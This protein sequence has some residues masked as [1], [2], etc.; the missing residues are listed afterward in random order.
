MMD[1]EGHA[2]NDQ[3]ALSGSYA[4]AQQVPRSKLL[5][6]VASICRT[7]K[8]YVHAHDAH[9]HAAVFYNSNPEK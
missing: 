4:Q 5:S 3:M 8:P 2:G 6:L 9:T 7:K 1:G